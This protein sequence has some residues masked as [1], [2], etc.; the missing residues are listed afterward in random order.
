[1]PKFSSVDS[2]FNK[3]VEVG[4]NDMNVAFV[5]GIDYVLRYINTKNIKSFCS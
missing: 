4:F 2:G 1:M 5:D 3:N